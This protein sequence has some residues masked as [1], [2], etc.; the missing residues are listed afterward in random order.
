MVV[1]GH[2][3]YA[4]LQSRKIKTSSSDGILWEEIVTLLDLSSASTIIRP[5][6]RQNKLLGKMVKAMHKEWK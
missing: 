5:I 1:G 6:C 2:F 4:Y 3:F